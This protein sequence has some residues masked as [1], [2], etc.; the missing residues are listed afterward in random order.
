MRSLSCSENQKYVPSYTEIHGKRGATNRPR[1][2]QCAAVFLKY[3][4]WPVGWHENPVVFAAAFCLP[5]YVH[6]CDDITKAGN[7]LS[8]AFV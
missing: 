2:S 4:Y 1:S 5:R 7:I 6:E 3:E 8:P